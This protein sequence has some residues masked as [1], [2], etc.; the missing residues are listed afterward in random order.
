MERPGMVLQSISSPKEKDDG[1][2]V[3]DMPWFVWLMVGI[4]ILGI[5]VCIIFA[6][7]A[8]CAKKPKRP[9]PQCEP[10]PDPPPQYDHREYPPVNHNNPI[11]HQFPRQ[12]PSHSTSPQPYQ[13]TRQP[14]QPPPHFYD[15]EKPPS[16]PQPYQPTGQPLQPP[17]HFFDVEKPEYA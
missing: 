14:V 10:S 15:V 16:S 6:V 1:F 3:L 9:P 17:P 4:A 5:I 13:P 8:L 12:T 2:N 7:L 11:E